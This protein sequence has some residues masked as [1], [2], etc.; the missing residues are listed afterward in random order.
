MI[1]ILRGGNVFAPEPL[2][3]Q[4]VVV[5]GERIAAVLPA[6][7]A[8]FSGVPVEELDISGKTLVPGFI[9]NHVHILGGGGE[10]GPA[11]R[12]P[13]IYLE[14]IVTSGVTTLIG[15]LGTDG[16]TRHMSSL[17]AKANALDHEGITTFLFTG[18]Y[19]IPVKTLTGSVKSDLILIHKV[20]GA[21]E[22]AVS[23]HRSAQPTFDE[24]ARLAAECRVGGMLGG[25]AGV[26]HCH[27]GDGSRRLQ[28]LFRLIRET[29][30]PATQVIPTHTNRNSE[31]LDE[32]IAFVKEGGFIDLTADLDPD[33][34]SDGHLSIARSIRR[35]LDKKIPLSR[36]TISSDSNGSMPVFDREGRLTGLTIATQKSLLANFRFLIENRVVELPDALLPL[37]RNPAVY[38]KLEQKGE[39]QVGKDADLLA[40]D[41][42]WALT[43]V[44]SRGR[45]MMAEGGLLAKSTFSSPHTKGIQV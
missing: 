23:D 13:E 5:A 17:L 19:E 31:L 30:I 9:D 6:G 28:H 4:D 8:A 21:G 22:I 2:G 33:P 32:G 41:R 16:T 24:F 26:L 11:T 38:Y 36:L 15:C 34:S 42:D 7:T 10:G 12:A 44:L 45:V 27:L 43:E 35:C 20:I 40:F 1:R 3:I 25:K 39:I 37:T 18:S 29:E 14:D